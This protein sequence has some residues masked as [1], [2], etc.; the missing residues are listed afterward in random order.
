MINILRPLFL[1]MPI[2]AACP[3][4]AENKN[5]DKSLWFFPEVLRLAFMTEIRDPAELNFRIN[6]FEKFIIE[7]NQTEPSFIYGEKHFVDRGDWSSCSDFK[8]TSIEEFFQLPPTIAKTQGTVYSQ[9]AVNTFVQGSFLLG[10]RSFEASIAVYAN[11]FNV[12]QII[13]P[14]TGR[15][16]SN[17][18]NKLAAIPNYDDLL[19]SVDNYLD[20]KKIEFHRQIDCGNGVQIFRVQGS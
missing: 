16:T 17:V 8:V 5:V 6:E 19:R 4:Y 2:V 18:R 1:L 9:V 12:D 7:Q 3:V 15:L 11:D 14:E 10:L 20:G 13:D